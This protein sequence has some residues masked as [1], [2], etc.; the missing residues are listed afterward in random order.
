MAIKTK[1]SEKVETMTNEDIWRFVGCA[2]HRDTLE[3]QTKR[4]EQRKEIF[5]KLR[6]GGIKP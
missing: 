2:V 1:P 4:D 6:G 5:R 3:I